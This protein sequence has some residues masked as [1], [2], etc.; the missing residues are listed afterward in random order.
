LDRIAERFK[1]HRDAVRRHMANHVTAEDCAVMVA[2]LPMRELV[3]QAAEEGVGVLDYLRVIRAVL[4]RQMLVAAEQGDRSGTALLSHRAIEC[5]KEVGR[6]TGE[7]SSLTTMTQVNN[8]AIFTSS[9]QWAA[10]Q[11]ML[12]ERLKGWPDALASVLE[13]MEELDGKA[14]PGG[15]T[16]GL[17]RPLAAI[18]HQGADRPHAG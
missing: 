14:A 18:E 11:T 4:M 3:E 8:T 9:P 12:I 17:G 6:I 13:G 1:V 5:L 16:P 2:D 7:I 15:T 10:L